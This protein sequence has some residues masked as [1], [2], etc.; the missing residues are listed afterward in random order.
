MTNIIEQVFGMADT[1]LTDQ[2]IA[3]DALLGLKGVCTAYL[4]GTLESATPE[5][6][7]M[8]S[9]Y[10]TQSVQAHEAMTALAI[11]KGWYNPY[12][13][14]DEQLTEAFEQSEWIIGTNEAVT[15]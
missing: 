12:I 10:L 7:R 11:K 4:G 6:R 3:N 15:D 13:N 1:K 8:W 9:E 2:V 14:P 5:V